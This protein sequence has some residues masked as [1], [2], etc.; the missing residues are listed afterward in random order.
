M[1][2]LASE[3]RKLESMFITIVEKKVIVIL[4]FLIIYLNIFLR[5]VWIDFFAA[6]IFCHN[7]YKT[8]YILN[9]VLFNFCLCLYL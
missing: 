9:N 6:Y 7:G 8:F 1:N 2:F 5:N 3:G 4:D